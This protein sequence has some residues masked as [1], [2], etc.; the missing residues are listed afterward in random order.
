MADSTSPTGSSSGV[1]RAWSVPYAR[2][3][4]FTGRDDELRDLHA[5]LHS[6]QPARRVQV[7]CGLGGI[8][9]TQLALEYLY[10]N[11]DQYNIVWWISADEPATLALGYARLATQLGMKIPEGTGLD[12]I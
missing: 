4:H 10:R 7:I 9:K 11:K 6:D 12:D 2:N 8:G 3:V 5:S 1:T